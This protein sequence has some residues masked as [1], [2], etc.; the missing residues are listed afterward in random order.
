MRARHS[1]F[2]FFNDTATT[3]IYTLSLH[4]AAASS[5]ALSTTRDDVCIVSVPRL[6]GRLPGNAVF[7]ERDL[8]FR[9]VRQCAHEGLVR[10]RLNRG[11]FRPRTVRALA[12]PQPQQLTL[13]LGVGA[14]H[15]AVPV[16]VA[17]GAP[18]RDLQLGWIT[19]QQ[20]RRL[21]RHFHA[22]GVDR[23]RD[24][25]RVA[26]REFAATRHKGRI[27]RGEAQELRAGVPGRALV[28]DLD[29]TRFPADCPERHDVLIETETT[30]R[31]QETTLA[32]P[33][34]KSADRGEARRGAPRP[35]EHMRDWGER[36]REGA[37]GGGFGASGHQQRGGGR[38]GGPA[39]RQKIFRGHGK[40]FPGTT[41]LG[42]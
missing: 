2:F 21:K 41:A 17:V 38:G 11:N 3:E 36:G 31:R 12:I 34:R 14:V 42:A 20:A 7:R 33:T 28:V 5:R 1:Y 4:D 15:Y 26:W 18:I 25:H 8:V 9:E 22:A 37:L 39:K 29:G 27:N 10:Q 35:A 6:P 16:Q 19:E 40:P 32:A 23:H 13:D 30:R 24:Q